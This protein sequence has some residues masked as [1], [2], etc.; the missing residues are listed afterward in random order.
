MLVTAMV[1]LVL[2][3]HS[4]WRDVGRGALAAAGIA[5]VLNAVTLSTLGIAMGS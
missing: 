3:R 1:A 2:S 5:F 4:E